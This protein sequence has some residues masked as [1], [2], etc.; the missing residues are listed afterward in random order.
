M[1]KNVRQYLLA[2]TDV[3][4]ILDKN[5]L[6]EIIDKLQKFTT[7]ANVPASEINVEYSQCDD[8]WD[9][10]SFYYNRIETDE[11][12]QERI[13]FEAK[14]DERRKE[15]ISRHYTKLRKELTELGLLDESGNLINSE[16]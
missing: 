6:Q 2:D 5:N 15:S 11:E 16:A 3:D 12:Y 14:E 10:I 13:A 4:I 8:G 7:E 1:K 9:E